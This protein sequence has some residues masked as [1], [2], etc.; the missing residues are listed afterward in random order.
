M[1]QNIQTIRILFVED[2]PTDVE[3]AIHEIKKEKIDFTYKVVDTENEFR[4]ELSDFDPDIV[5]SDYSMPAF[6]GMSALE[7]A[8]SR[9]RY[10]PFI[11]L[12][13][14]M[15][16]ETAVA[17][18]KASANDYVIKEQIKRL[19]F[20]VLEAIEKRKAVAEKEKAEQDLLESEAKYRSLIEK[21]NDAIY[22]IYE[23]KFEIINARFE[24][25]FG[26]SFSEVNQPGFD[27]IKLV[28]PESREYVED[29]LGKIANGEKMDVLYEFTAIDKNGVKKEVETSVSYIDFKKG[30][31]VQGVIRD[32]SERKKL[33]AALI[34]AKEKAEESDKLKTAFL[35]N[36]S[37][38]IRTP[39]NGIM[40][41]TELLKQPGLTGE[42]QQEFIGI[43]QKSGNR[44]LETISNLV[45]ISK[46][47]TGQVI[48]QNSEINIPKQL[49]YLHC[50]F[51][52]QADEK[53][54]QLI[55]N[56]NLPAE[57][58][59]VKTDIQKLDSIFN[60]LINNA[61]KFTDKGK[62]I[63]GCGHEKN[64]LVFYIQDAGI[65]IPEA[66]REAIF[67]RFVQAEI[68]YTRDFEGSGLGLPIAKSYIEMLGGTIWLESEEEKGSTFYFTLP[69]Q[70]EDN[71]MQ[72]NE[73]QSSP[74][75]PKRM[76]KKMKILVAEDDGT[77]YLYIE[78]LL[79]E[80]NYEII[81]S[82]T[83]SETIELCKNNPDIDIILMDIKMPEIDGYEATRKI[84]QF[85]PGII[86]IAQTAYALEG[87]RQK[88]I[89]AGCNDYIP[90]PIRKDELLNMINRFA[91]DK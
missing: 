7:I 40:G 61:I 27:F 66:R 20:A 12:T 18:M 39:M 62:I 2:L 3:L 6:D 85:N 64:R 79:E 71:L 53:G 46:I 29:S 76:N 83:G 25:M 23:R 67:N 41:F 17:C 57:Y 86:I 43:I 89:D 34:E 37:H 54:L 80:Y 8:R 69:F 87:D 59:V 81:R 73:L 14:S 68:S 82:K 47:E 84:R 88:A 44:M 36:I 28:A 26:Y 51:K 63:I 22:L 75:E 56:C 50:F 19:P 24:Q 52:P 5:V 38:E 48:I 32:I 31:A 4:K 1:K 33:I 42:E 21:S 30:K 77:S 60:N 35:T 10:L 72:K 13:G 16:E 74:E 78:T 90:K 91:S 70:T 9:N 45:D 58:A 65:G 49:E 15:N 55:L 11:I